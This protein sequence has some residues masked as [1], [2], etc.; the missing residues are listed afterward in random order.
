MGSAIFVT[1]RMWSEVIAAWLRK[2]TTDNFKSDVARHQGRAGAA[3]EQ[4]LHGV[5]S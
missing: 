4:A 5:W 3:Y 2:P 1:K